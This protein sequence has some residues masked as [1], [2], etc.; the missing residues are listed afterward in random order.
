MCCS[1]SAG[2]VPFLPG[3]D[4][5]ALL[6]NDLGRSLFSLNDG[7]CDLLLARLARLDAAPG[8]SWR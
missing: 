2:L 8:G 5:D 4:V 1:S 6:L 3:A 7:E